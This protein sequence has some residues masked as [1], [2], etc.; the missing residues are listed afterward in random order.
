MKEGRRFGVDEA[1]M[2]P[3]P[4]EEECGRSGVDSPIEIEARDGL[5]PLPAPLLTPPLCAGILYASQPQIMLA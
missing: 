5:L 2:V 3:A 1:P 4:V